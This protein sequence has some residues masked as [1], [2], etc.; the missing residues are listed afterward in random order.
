MMF[1]PLRQRVIQRHYVYTI[2][3][4]K[5][6]SIQIVEMTFL[7]AYKYKISISLYMKEFPEFLSL[8][9]FVDVIIHLQQLLS[10]HICISI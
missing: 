9:N 5:R 8:H 7:S 10:I 3:I 6:M 4:V 1:E 2:N